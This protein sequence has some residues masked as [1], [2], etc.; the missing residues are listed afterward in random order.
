MNLSPNATAGEGA[1]CEGCS[2]ARA[3]HLAYKWLGLG[4]KENHPAEASPSPFQRGK[5]WLRRSWLSSPQDMAV[6]PSAHHTELCSAPVRRVK[7][8][9]R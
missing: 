1:L 8:C 7:G 4:A 3:L 2:P 5:A 6:L 9:A